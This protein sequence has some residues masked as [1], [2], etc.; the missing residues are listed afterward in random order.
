MIVECSAKDC[1]ETGPNKGLPYRAVMAMDFGQFC[2]VS[3]QEASSGN[4]HLAPVSHQ[5][6]IS[7]ASGMD[8]QPSS[9][10]I[11]HH[12]TYACVPQQQ[13]L[14]IPAV[15]LASGKLLGTSGDVTVKSDAAG[16]PSIRFAARTSAGRLLCS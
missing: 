11:L 4:V 5:P 3:N 15:T 12:W 10:H 7:T 9:A 6:Y 1:P 2:F 8:T 13:R 16:L 14:Q